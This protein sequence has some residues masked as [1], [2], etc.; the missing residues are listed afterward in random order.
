MAKLRRM[1]CRSTACQH[2]PP[3]GIP[4]IQFLIVLSGINNFLT[5]QVLLQ[6]ARGVNPLAK[7]SRKGIPSGESRSP[8]RETR[9]LPEE[10]TFGISS[11]INEPPY[12]K[13]ASHTGERDDPPTADHF[14]GAPFPFCPFS[15]GRAKENGRV[16][17]SI[18]SNRIGSNSAFEE[19]SFSCLDTRERTKEKVKAGEKTAKN[20]FAELKR[21]PPCRRYRATRCGIPQYPFLI[22]MTGIKFVISSKHT[23]DEYS[24]LNAPLRNFLN[25]I[26]SQADPNYATHQVPRRDSQVVGPGGLRRSFVRYAT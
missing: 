15:F 14:R 10:A 6:S 18:Y 9:N 11:A 4:H 3:C 20:F 1:R 8:S 26:F 23:G 25:A 2:M 24:F 21:M 5:G 16:S 12:I 19:R 7:M 22:L 17:L 13:V